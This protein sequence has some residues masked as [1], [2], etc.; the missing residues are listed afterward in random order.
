MKIDRFQY[1]PRNGILRARPRLSSGQ[2]AG[3]IH[4]VPSEMHHVAS[5]ARPPLPTLQFHRSQRLKSF[6]SSD[7][8]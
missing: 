3:S 4:R 6:Q 7:D 5:A 1:I 2:H 8:R